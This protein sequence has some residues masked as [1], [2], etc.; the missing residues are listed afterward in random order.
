MGDN[1]VQ[2][3][4]DDIYFLDCPHK[5]LKRQIEGTNNQE[6]DSM[7]DIPAEKPFAF[8]CFVN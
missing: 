6:L 7:E 5:R 4:V 3:K 1:T 2:I 8:C